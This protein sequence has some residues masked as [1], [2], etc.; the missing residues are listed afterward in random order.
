MR[1]TRREIGKLALTA[2]PG[3]ALAKEPR[4]PFGARAQTAAVPNSTIDGVR[5]GAITYSYRSMPDQSAHAILRYVLD[6]GISQIEIMGA[7]VE[8][9]AGA[10]QGERGGGRR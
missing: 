8:A 6:S 2:L 7:P 9:F 5:V 3:I 10:P 1:Y 4:F